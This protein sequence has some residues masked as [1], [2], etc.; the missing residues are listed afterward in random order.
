MTN[1]QWME[2]MKESIAS[3]D[4]QI[5]EL[6]DRMGDLTDRMGDLTDR[7]AAQTA[8]I[9]KLVKVTNEDAIAIRSLARIADAHESRL[10]RLEGGD[11]R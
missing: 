11:A 8:N 5:G 4:R 2:F 3:H 6:T 10:D 7:I 1:E 9:D